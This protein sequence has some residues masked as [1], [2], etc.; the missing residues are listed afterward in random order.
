MAG[1]TIAVDRAVRR[2]SFFRVLK[3]QIST[4]VI[5]DK[6]PIFVLILT[7]GDAAVAIICRATSIHR[8][9]APAAP[10]VPRRT[11][12]MC[13]ATFELARTEFGN[14]RPELLF[15]RLALL[16]GLRRQW[17][18]STTTTTS[19]GVDG[20]A[21]PLPP[22]VQIEMPTAFL[23]IFGRTV[24]ELTGRPI[25]LAMQDC[26]A[27]WRSASAAEKGHLSIKVDTAHV[28][29]NGARVR[30]GQKIVRPNLACVFAMN[31]ERR[32]RFLCGHG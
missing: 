28:C 1:R 10:H 3:S 23:Y 27:G 11:A 12:V 32:S 24:L 31:A 9:I 21:C 22:S 25:R 29:S 19:N 4:D 18:S 16:D 17:S 6:S 15:R 5:S 8:E 20:V 7:R 13:V 26:N 2:D 30:H 14:R